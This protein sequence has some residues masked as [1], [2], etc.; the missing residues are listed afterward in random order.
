M[1]IEDPKDER[2]IANS[3]K[4]LFPDHMFTSSSST[5]P[6]VNGRLSVTLTVSSRPVQKLEV[7]KIENSQY[8][9]RSEKLSVD[10]LND[11]KEWPYDNF[12]SKLI[13]TGCILT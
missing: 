6:G 5:V 10:F 2:K 3:L 11:T 8:R 4:S 7:L 9:L 13:I 12:S 1:D